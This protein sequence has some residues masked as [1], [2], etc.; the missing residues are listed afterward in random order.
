MKCFIKYFKSK[1]AKDVLNLFIPKDNECGVNYAFRILNRLL[2]NVKKLDKD[3]DQ[4]SIDNC[5]QTNDTSYLTNNLLII[6][7]PS[8]NRRGFL[9]FDSIILNY[10]WFE[11]EKNKFDFLFAYVCEGS[12]VLEKAN[13]NNI[14]KG[15]ASFNNKIYFIFN[16][17]NL[18]RT[19]GGL[20]I[21]INRELSD[22]SDNEVFKQKIIQSIDKSFIKSA[23]QF[24]EANGDQLLLLLYANLYSHLI[25]KS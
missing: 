10:N 13:W 22:V 7:H 6:G 18:E 8:T 16:N 21:N 23:K 25:F 3:F 19:F 2:R 5:I 15:W 11:T 20:F 14:F 9:A 1:T 4:E 24:N 12:N 17:T